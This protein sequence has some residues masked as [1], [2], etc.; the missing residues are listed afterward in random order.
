MRGKSLALA[1]IPLRVQRASY[2][3]CDDDDDEE[4][5]ENEDEDED[6]DFCEIQTP[7]DLQISTVSPFSLPDD[8]VVEEKPR[9]PDPH[10][11]RVQVDRV[12]YPL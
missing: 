3:E 4:Q 1:A 10:G 9:P 8:W 2:E 5:N 7:M 6:E 11:R 12:N